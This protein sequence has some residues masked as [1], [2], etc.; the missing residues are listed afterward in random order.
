MLT[1]RQKR[2]VQLLHV[3]TDYLPVAKIAAS[4]GCSVKTV[5]NDLLAISDAIGASDQGLIMAK[6]NRGIRLKQEG[7]LSD[8]LL[9]LSEGDILGHDSISQDN[10]GNDTSMIIF[11]LFKRQSITVEEIEKLVYASRGA[12]EKK[13]AE[14]VQRLQ[15]LNIILQRRRGIGLYI[16]YREIDYRIALWKLW[17]LF[18]PKLQEDDH[19]IDTMAPAH[20]LSAIQARSIAY[21]LDGFD[22]T[23]VGA[24]IYSLEQ[25]F[26][27][28]LNYESYTRM[29]FLLAVMISRCRRKFFLKEPFASIPPLGPPEQEIV[30]RIEQWL[31]HECRISLLDF[32]RSF[33]QFI[34]RTSEIERFINQDF[35]RRFITGIPQLTLFAKKIITTVGDVLR[36]DFSGD[37]LLEENLIM[38]LRSAIAWLQTGTRIKSKLLDQIRHKY[39]RIYAA[40]WSADTVFENETGYSAGSYEFSLI[41]LHFINAI[42]RAAASVRAAIICNYGKG[43]TQLIREEIEHSVF[44]IQITA[45]L[46]TRDTEMFHAADYD[47]FIS[48]V[49][50]PNPYYGREVIYLDHYMFPIDADRIQLKVTEIRQRKIQQP[51]ATDRQL[52]H[53]LFFPDQVFLCPEVKAKEEVLG[54]ICGC[55]ANSGLVTPEFTES[56]IKRE[57]ISSTCIGESIALPHGNPQFVNRPVIA[58]AILKQA[59]HWQNNDWV[60]IVFLLALS[61]EQQSALKQE[62]LKFYSFISRLLGNEKLVE[63]YLSPSSEIQFAEMM[64]QALEEM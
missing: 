14:I 18:S 54:F 61:L 11:L 34:I 51:K 33:L 56:V 62:I 26:G 8:R 55:L 10:W 41:A 1:G 44:G 47:C 48:M 39:A 32:D 46:N 53:R 52:A 27:F 64:N 36:M 30:R 15:E 45:S 40:V 19:Q 58:V 13:I 9:Q 20:R 7:Q 25:D 31:I 23:P 63:K 57:R 12:V 29:L 38:S 49:P 43:I 35:Y 50:V 5:R 42:E 60:R 16:L 22:A 37:M 4:I 59:I 17:C 2:I 21:F 3:A 24:L 28:Q 6:P